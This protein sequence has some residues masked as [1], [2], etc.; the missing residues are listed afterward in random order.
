MVTIR[1]PFCGY[2]TTWCVRLNGED[3]SCCPNKIES[4][5]LTKC[6]YDHWLTN[7]AYLSAITV[8]DITLLRVFTYK[9]AAKINRH[10]CGTKL[11]H[12]RP[13]YLSSTSDIRP[14][15]IQMFRPS[16]VC[17]CVWEYVL[18]VYVCVF[19]RVS[20]GSN[21]KPHI[22]GWTDRNAVCDVDSGSVNYSLD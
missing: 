19:V 3:L 16:V 20:V 13:M 1:S 6:Q 15:A 4:V 11:R 10:R 5:S 12:Y 7:K 22:S 2:N 17:L 9:M 14:I 8:T 18:C 21:C